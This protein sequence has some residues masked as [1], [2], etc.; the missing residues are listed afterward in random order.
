MKIIK[1]IDDTSKIKVTN[2]LKIPDLKKINNND[3][4]YLE[5]IDEISKVKDFY[6]SA[7]L[8]NKYIF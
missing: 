1:K 6:F 4:L 8:L 7:Y 3:K 5:I 2:A